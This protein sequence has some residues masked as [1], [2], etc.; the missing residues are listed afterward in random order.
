MQ[1]KYWYK[2][3]SILLKGVEL[4]SDD[5]EDE[6]PNIKNVYYDKNSKTI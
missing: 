6:N 5:I 1:N 2:N 4:I 3:S